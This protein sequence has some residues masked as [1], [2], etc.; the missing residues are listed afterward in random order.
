[1]I[2]EYHTQTQKEY[3]IFSTSTREHA[4]LLPTAVHVFLF[5][6]RGGGG[7]GGGG[8]GVV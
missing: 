8:G 5:F 4:C 1:M 6:L 3:Y 2:L 7:G